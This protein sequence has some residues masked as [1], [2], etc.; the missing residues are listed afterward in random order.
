MNN[1]YIIAQ[2]LGLVTIIF[3]FSSYQIQDKRKYFL[4]TG[5]GSFFWILM[6][7]A[8]GFATGIDTQLTLIVA[9]VYST[10]RNFVFFRMFSENTPESKEKWLNF[11]LL[12]ISIALIVGIVSV[13]RVPSSIRWIHLLG[14]VT[15]LLFAVGQYMPGVHW[16]RITVVLCSAAVLL[17]QTPLNIL[18]G[19]FRWNIMGILIEA[20]K[21][22]S[23][24]IFYV[25][26]ITKH[27]TPQLQLEK[28]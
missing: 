10:I 14:L 21:I 6:F 7:I 3:E 5:I 28:P 16:V 17:T 25:G 19:D 1:W 20:T 15:A 11:L 9:G 18:Y 4:T 12:M 2:I 23:V 13:L 22:I 24:V 8:I 27:K 26:Y